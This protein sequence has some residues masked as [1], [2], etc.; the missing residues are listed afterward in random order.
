[1]KN[2]SL[3]FL[4]C[5]LFYLNLQ[6]QIEV[7]GTVT[8]EVRTHAIPS[9]IA[10][11]ITNTDGRIVYEGGNPQVISFQTA[12]S[13][14]PL[15]NTVYTHIIDFPSDGVYEFRAYTNPGLQ[16]CCAS[17]EAY[18]RIIDADGN[19]LY[20]AREFMGSMATAVNVT[21]VPNLTDAAFLKN[22]GVFPEIQG[23]DP[24]KYK[25]SVDFTNSG[26]ND[27]ESA[28]FDF[29]V[30]DNVLTT[31]NWTGT[32]APG[33]SGFFIFDEVTI[34]E[35]GKLEVRINSIN[36]KPNSIDYVN[37][38]KQ[39]FEGFLK[40]ATRDID[41]SFK[42]DDMGHELFWEFA[43]TN[44]GNV[45]KKGGN[46]RV[47]SL[48]D[49]MNFPV[50]VVAQPSDP[51]AYMSQEA[52]SVNL[53]SR[54][55][56]GCYVLRLYDS[57]GNGFLNVDG[58]LQYT[59]TTGLVTTL[60]FFFAPKIEYYIDFDFPTGVA[61]N[62]LEGISDFSVFPNPTSDMINLQFSMKSEANLEISLV[63][64]LGQVVDV[65][66]PMQKMNG[67][68]SLEKSVE[69]LDSGMYLVRIT[70]GVNSTFKKVMVLK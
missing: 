46:E 55:V 37:S 12:Q 20:E 49:I 11:E 34:E 63:N 52:V 32:L 67:E 41:F 62:D 58:P 43:F 29:L 36:G 15:P 22:I 61:V 5:S 2:I 23:C 59:D 50:G 44:N 28:E 8:L 31:K 65:L 35:S 38:M 9:F 30:N 25:Q 10:W 68:I 42:T 21:G 53:R 26:S 60:P 33:A 18:A 48:K 3:I 47:E 69:T 27:I 4:F 14:Y 66:L 51:G 24:L 57:G 70:D 17:G 16:F 13:S 6:G 45:I 40:A 54:A 19:L 1:M 64:R 39:S 56:G 7:T